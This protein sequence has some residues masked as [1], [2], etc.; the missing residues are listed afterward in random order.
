M[1]AND[2]RMCTALI[3]PV[4][5]TLGLAFHWLSIFSLPLAEST[6]Q[7]AVLFYIKP[8]NSFIFIQMNY[9]F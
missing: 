9:G 4:L 1:V 8:L 6:V 5:G 2:K 3:C 7:T